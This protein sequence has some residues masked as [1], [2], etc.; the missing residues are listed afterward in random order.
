MFITTP[1]SRGFTYSFL[2]VEPNARHNNNNYTQNQ[3]QNQ[4]Q[5]QSN[6]NNNNNNNMN[7]YQ[8]RTQGAAV[9]GSAA[10]ATHVRPAYNPNFVAKPYHING[11]PQPNNN[12][13]INNG[14]LKR[15]P[16][17]KTYSSF[18]SNV[19]QLHH[20]NHKNSNPMNQQLQQHQPQQGVIPFP[21]PPPGGFNNYPVNAMM[22]MGMGM[23]GMP[24]MGMNYPGMMGMGMGGMM[25]GQDGSAMWGAGAAGVGGMNGFGG[26]GMM[27]DMTGM[28]GMM[29]M[30]GM[31]GMGNISGGA[32]GGTV[33]EE[34]DGSR[35]RSRMDGA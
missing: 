20:P 32:T 31:M 7:N 33:E 11:N 16:I 18:P 34:M 23:P 21:P 6:Y 14:N 2:H 1:S 5:N 10:P 4:N 26:F 29:G 19:T 17:T 12:S 9:A 22:G 30:N 13:N 28:T 35:K 15:D 3:N 25:G 8:N 27:G 24:G